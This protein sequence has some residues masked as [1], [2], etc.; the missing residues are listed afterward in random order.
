MSPLSYLE[1]VRIILMSPL[2]RSSWITLS[3]LYNTSSS[4][5]QT[6][7]GLNQ[8]T[9]SNYRLHGLGHCLQTKPLSIL[10]A[11]Y[12][13]N[14]TNAFKFFLFLNFFPTLLFSSKYKVQ[15]SLLF[16]SVLFQFKT[17]YRFLSSICTSE[18][19]W[20]YNPTPLPFFFPDRNWQRRAGI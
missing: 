19:C 4:H 12:S 2:V 6:K 16:H 3:S 20:N 11:N 13:G 7:I 8:P 15:I 10:L 9:N 14:P 1:P 17:V 18:D 5:L